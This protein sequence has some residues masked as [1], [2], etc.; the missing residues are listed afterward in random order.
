MTCPKSDNGRHV[1]VGKLFCANCD[2][3]LSI[4]DV[5]AQ[6]RNEAFDEVDRLIGMN[7]V[8]ISE[9]E[10]ELE[11]TKFLE[12]FYVLK[13]KAERRSKKAERR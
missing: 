6:A 12:A 1:I 11:S 4:A 2:T 10:N 9:D 7:S 8:C 5:E 3:D 13:E